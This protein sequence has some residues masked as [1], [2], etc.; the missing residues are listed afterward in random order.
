MY[1]DIVS[2]TGKAR[3]TLGVFQVGAR[4]RPLQGRCVPGA[5]GKQP[6]SAAVSRTLSLLPGTCG[7]VCWVQSH[8]VFS[9]VRWESERDTDCFL[10]LVAN[11][12]HHIF[13]RLS[14]YQLVLLNDLSC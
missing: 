13:S 3:C 9:S 7:G 1:S 4:M 5:F 2:N 11:C 10:F 6:L 8:W 14:S 12:P